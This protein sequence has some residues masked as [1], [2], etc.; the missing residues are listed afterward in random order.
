MNFKKLPA[1]CRIVIIFF[2]VG[3]I[4]GCLT[5]YLLKGEFYSSLVGVY[6]NILSK[7]AKLNVDKT[8]IFLTSLRHHLKL[9][10]LFIIFSF[11]NLWRFYYCGFTAYTG[12]ST[13]LLLM[14]H[15]LLDGINGITGFFCCLF[16]QCILYGFLYL[17]LI[18]RLNDF[19]YEFVSGGSCGTNKKEKLI[20]HQL[21]FLFMILLLL[22]ISSMTEAYINLPLL[23]WLSV[24]H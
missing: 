1:T 3:M 10:F 5:G 11:T 16:P 13:G 22:I 23:S 7:I 4:M 19:H 18:L 21:P 24:R 9:I 17:L 20:L 8:D 12:F 14:F 6:T 15:L 2:I